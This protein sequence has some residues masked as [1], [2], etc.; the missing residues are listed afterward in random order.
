[1]NILLIID[2]IDFL[3]VH[4]LKN[5]TFY[6]GSDSGNYVPSDIAD[7]EN[8]LIFMFTRTERADEE[9]VQ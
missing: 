1:M 4:L 3:V 5:D 6:R 9:R 8:C 7:V 2:F